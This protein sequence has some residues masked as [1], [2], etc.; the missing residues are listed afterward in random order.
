M[1]H[2]K[3]CSTVKNNSKPPLSKIKIEKKYSSILDSIPFGIIII[4]SDSNLV[5]QN[6][7][8]LRLM[9]S[10]SAR[11]N[12]GA[13]SEN[14]TP[15]SVL[16]HGNLLNQKGNLI[17][18]ADSY[19]LNEAILE[20]YDNLSEFINTIAANKTS[21]RSGQENICTLEPR[22]YI[23]L[24]S[25]GHEIN[26]FLTVLQLRC[27]LL[28]MIAHD[29]DKVTET[30]RQLHL[31]LHGLKQ[32]ANNLLF[33]GKKSNAKKNIINA[34]WFFE[35]MIT[36]PETA[37]LFENYAV[38]LDKKTDHLYVKVDPENLQ[39]FYVNS[40]VLAS[41]SDP[42]NEKLAVNFS[43]G[44]KNVKI[45]FSYANKS[46]PIKEFN[47]YKNINDLK[48]VKLSNRNVI[49]VS[50]ILSVRDM[51]GKIALNINKNNKVLLTATLPL[52]KP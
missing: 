35:D 39:N 14:H 17:N 48:Q 23:C 43:G 29:K 52:Y 25:I 21:Q 49:V 42:G 32:Y 5:F 50:I 27:E 34:I 18:I 38:A 37:E 19:E 24:N 7:T 10:D 2:E 12:E 41:H 51:D 26:N 13:G 47:E 3:N 16:L 15:E 28:K 11:K 33:L 46:F 22:E 20:I 8:A 6:R 9:K 4:D 30:V 36:R 31:N 40:I 45:S 1:N 44:Q